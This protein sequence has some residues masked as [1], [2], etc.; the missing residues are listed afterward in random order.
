MTTQLSVNVNKIAVVRNSRGGHDPDVVQAARTCIAA[1]AH[2]ITVHPRPDQRHIRDDDV[3]ALSALTREHGVEFNIEGN[4]FAPPR[5]GYPGLLELCGATR[6]EQVT[7]V[8]DSDGQLTSDHGFD[9][10]QDT[11]HLGELI[12]TFKALGSRVSLFVD[13]GNPHLD[14][15]AALGADRIE[16]YTGPYAHAHASGQPQTE[17]ALFADAARLATAAG[18]GINAGHDLSQ[19]NLGDF[20]AT[21][22]GVLEVSIGHALISEALYT[23]LDTTVRAYVQLLRGVGTQM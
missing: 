19:A 23:G 17:L 21:V 12:A 11:A 18:L 20:L 4:P 13:A 22:P 10:A 8:P 6:P 5:A 3:L 15:A 16:L 7:L 9:F 2:G 1:G 14:Q